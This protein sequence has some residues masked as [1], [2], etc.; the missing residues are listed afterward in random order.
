[1]R[2]GQTHK[3]TDSVRTKLK[4]ERKGVRKMKFQKRKKEKRNEKRKK[5]C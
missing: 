1:M 5:S 4:K 3:Q 2:M